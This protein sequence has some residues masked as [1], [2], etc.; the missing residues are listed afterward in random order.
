MLFEKENTM[1]VMFYFFAGWILPMFV[2]CLTRVFVPDVNIWYI[3]GSALSF[4][5]FIASV[6][7]GIKLQIKIK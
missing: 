6:V 5:V 7:E 4:I 3:I 1:F 2:F